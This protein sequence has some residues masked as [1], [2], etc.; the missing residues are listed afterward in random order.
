MG[1][2]LSKIKRVCTREQQVRLYTVRDNQNMIWQ[3]L[4]VNDA[5]YPVEG[6]KLTL[7]MLCMIWELGDSASKTWDMLE[8]DLEDAVQSGLVDP[9]DAENLRH[10]P[11]MVDK[12]TIPNI[13]M[14]RVFDAQAIR[15]E[16]GRMTL[17]PD[18]RC[19]PCWYGPV[20]YM[21]IRED[22]LTVAAYTDGVLSG[23]IRPVG[24]KVAAVANATLKALAACECVGG[25]D[26]NND[27]K[28][29]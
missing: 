1:V 27:N 10:T 9:E 4:G 26:D 24:Y 5:L 25:W 8:M 16:S 29:G 22:R 17:L 6:V 18:S 14:A 7:N 11:A 21:L 2:K 12:A 23:I 15:L 3:W 28:G 19:A 20:E 13:R